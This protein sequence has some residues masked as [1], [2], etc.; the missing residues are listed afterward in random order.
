MKWNSADKT[1]NMTLSNGD[2]TAQANTSNYEW[3]RTNRNNFNTD[4]DGKFYWE[5]LID[6]STAG[7][8]HIGMIRTSIAIV[9]ES[10]DPLTAPIAEW[11]N[12]GTLTGNTWTANGTADTFT[13]GDVLMFALDVDN[14]QLFLGKNG[15]WQNSSDPAAGTNA[16]FTTMHANTDCSFFFGTDN[17]A[18]NDQVTLITDPG[19]FNYSVP[20]GFSAVTV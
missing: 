7:D 9:S 17:N 12:S 3:V 1:T 14:A 18:G 4:T 15:T 8:I 19:D 16:S 2:L 10:A 6:A 13:A 5:V 11:R 20:T